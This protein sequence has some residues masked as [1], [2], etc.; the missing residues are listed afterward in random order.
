MRY[1][2]LLLLML[3]LPLYTQ[4]QSGCTDSRATNYSPNATTNNGSC[5][6]ANTTVSPVVRA[7]LPTSIKET[8]G[9]L[10]DNGYLWTHNDSG[11]SPKLYKLDTTTGQIVQEVTIANASNIDWEDLAQDAQ[12]IYIGDFGNNDGNR[13]D[14]R[15]L[16]LNKASIG[17]GAQVSVSVQSIAFRYP[18][19]TSWARRAVHNFDCEAF[20]CHQDTLH[21]FTKNWAN[22][23]TKH[24]VLPT[25][26]GNYNARLIDSFN[27]RCTISGADII[28]DPNA[29]IQLILIGYDKDVF[30]ACTWAVW[31]FQHLGRCWQGNKRRIDLPSVIFV[32]Q[33][34]A[35]AYRDFNR[36]FI[37]NEERSPVTA[38]L[39]TFDVARFSN[40]VTNVAR[41]I[42]K[43]EEQPLI[44]ANNA[45]GRLQLVL[46]KGWIVSGD[47]DLADAKGQLWQRITPVAGTTVYDIDTVQLPPATYFLLGNGPKGSFRV[48]FVHRP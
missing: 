11:N 21:L 10:Y 37:S 46:P 8:S 35:I 15:I 23:Q 20:V 22:K 28:E 39:Y 19:Q 38:R 1:S 26:P 17:T 12:H 30:S 14:L 25:V 32:G 33:V 13:T 2:F 47:I 48:S 31:D 43:V 44:Y 45:A 40:V 6:Y 4:A 16:V 3:L 36:I 34:E 18:D 27:V 5:T 42:R 24:Y 9:L 7:T 41:T 29:G